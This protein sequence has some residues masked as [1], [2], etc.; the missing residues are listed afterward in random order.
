MKKENF[1]EAERLTADTKEN[2]TN[3]RKEPKGADKDLRRARDRFTSLK[4]QLM[5]REAVLETPGITIFDIEPVI[6]Q[7][8]ERLNEFKL[9]SLKQF[10]EKTVQCVTRHARLSTRLRQIVRELFIDDHVATILRRRI[11][12]FVGSA[13]EFQDWALATAK[14]EREGVEA[15]ALWWKEHRRTVLRGILRI[16]WGCTDLGFSGELS[17]DE[18][19]GDPE[20]N[21]DDASPDEESDLR[22]QKPIRVTDPIAAE[23]ET[24]AWLKIAHDAS[25][26]LSSQKPIGEQLYWFGYRSAWSWRQQRTREKDKLS[27]TKFSVGFHGLET[28]VRS[29]SGERVVQ[30]SIDDARDPNADLNPIIIRD[31]PWTNQDLEREL[32]RAG[33]FR[34]DDPYEGEIGAQLLAAA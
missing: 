1:T 12:E 27:S 26:I 6:L 15:L 25:K 17:G 28:I 22:D 10:R 2:R 13:E 4:T 18:S 30:V 11:P 31:L 21:A 24:E 34:A 20:G 5:L 33:P 32:R 7:L 19:N 16:L 14:Q 8:G 29:D 23:L 9:L 3:N